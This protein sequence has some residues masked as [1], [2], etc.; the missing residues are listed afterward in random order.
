MF[1]AAGVGSQAVEPAAANSYVTESTPEPEPSSAVASSV[2]MPLT[3]APGLARLTL[4]AVLSTRTF[5]RSAETPVFPAW[6]VATTRRSYRP[7]AFAVVSQLSGTSLH[8]PA[9][10]GEPW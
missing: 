8:V 1:H 3:F 2:T 5:V 9:P 4:G 10:A 7:S 6:S